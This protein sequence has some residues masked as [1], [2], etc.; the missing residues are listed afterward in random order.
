[1][2]IP[3]FPQVPD[4]KK[5]EG[6][7]YILCYNPTKSIQDAAFRQA[8]LQEAEKPYMPMLNASSNLVNGEKTRSEK[9]HCKGC[10][11]PDSK[12]HASLFRCRLWWTNLI[13]SSQ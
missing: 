9:Y 6:V 10:G 11:N 2:E 8:A 3:L 7:R 1:L 12:E 4:E 5:D 13:V